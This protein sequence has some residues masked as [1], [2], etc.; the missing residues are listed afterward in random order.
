M[1]PRL[2]TFICLTFVPTRGVPAEFAGHICDTCLTRSLG[3]MERHKHLVFV[4]FITNLPSSPEAVESSFEGGALVV[5]VTMRD[6][7]GCEERALLIRGLNPSRR[8]LKEVQAGPLIEGRIDYLANF[9]ASE[10]FSTIVVPED[11]MW[12]IGLTN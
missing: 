2:S 6:S 5:E 3:L 9:A 7:N 8:L 11:E 1:L 12:G 10:G 4:L